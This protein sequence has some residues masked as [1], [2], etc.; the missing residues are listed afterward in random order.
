M[1]RYVFVLILIIFLSNSCKRENVAY[2]RK[3]LLENY[4]SGR[5]DVY[6]RFD[7]Y[8]LLV[9]RDLKT[10]CT[11]Q[12][13]NYQIDELVVK[14]VDSLKDNHVIILSDIGYVNT[15]L[16][17]LMQN[18]NVIFLKEGTLTMEDYGFFMKPTL[19]HICNLKLLEWKYCF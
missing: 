15:G 17:L 19:F 4:L 13:L 3:K 9:I 11:E 5:S 18:D 2:P 12:Y 1:V 6:K 10:T 14:I 8:Y 7:N 16:R